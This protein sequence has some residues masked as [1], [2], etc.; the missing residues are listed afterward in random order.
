MQRDSVIGTFT[1][2]AVLCV[3]C[4]LLVAGTAEA[5]RSKISNNAELDR[6]KNI[7]I[8]AGLADKSASPKEVDSIYEENITEVMIDLA[9]G[10]VVSESDLPPGYDPKKA[11]NDPSLKV[12]VENNALM[13]IRYREPYAPVYELNSGGYVLPVYGKGLWGTL[14]GFLALEKD[15]KTVK[16]LTFYSHKETPGLGAEVD[17]P[18]WK[19][20]W[21]GKD[22]ID[23]EG[24]VLIHVKKGQTPP[25]SPEAAYTIDGLSGATITTKGVDHLIN[26]WLGDNGFGKFLAKQ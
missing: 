13:G 18:N 24:D 10:A 26:Y 3:A 16:G 25:D 20:Q 2:A 14:W 1:V 21:P 15:A 9:T 5:L 19:A 22:A 11:S 23:E 17:N 4:S 8:A 6:K 12:P 7:L